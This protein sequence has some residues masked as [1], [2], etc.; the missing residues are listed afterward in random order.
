MKQ[1]PSTEPCE[2]LPCNLP[3]SNLQTPTCL[4][5][6]HVHWTLERNTPKKTRSKSQLVALAAPVPPPLLPAFPLRWQG[7][8]ST[9]LPVCMEQGCFSKR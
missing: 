5:A 7:V 8:R 2:P 3:Q 6:R 9:R 4:C 1:R